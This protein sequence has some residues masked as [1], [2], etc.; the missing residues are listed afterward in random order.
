LDNGLALAVLA[1]VV[2][3]VPIALVA[4][5]VKLTSKGPAVYI[6]PPNCIKSKPTLGDEYGQGW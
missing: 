2:L 1:L 6:T 3:I 5:A 4:L